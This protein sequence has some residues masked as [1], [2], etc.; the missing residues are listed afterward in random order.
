MAKA[1]RTTHRSSKNKKLYAVRD[2]SGRFKGDLLEEIQDLRTPT[3]GLRGSSLSR[4]AFSSV[5]SLQALRNCLT[6][7][8]TTNR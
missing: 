7:I 8:R 2:A 4:G 5:G 3:T 6:T 1:G